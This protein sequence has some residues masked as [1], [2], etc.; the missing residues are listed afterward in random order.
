MN[1]GMVY[2]A[3]SRR[4]IPIDVATNT[5]SPL[6]LQ[7]SIADLVNHPDYQPV[8][9]RIIAKR[10]G[11]PKEEAADVR[12]MVK[13]LVQQGLVT[14]ASN[15][16]VRPVSRSKETE[17]RSQNEIERPSPS[18]ASPEGREPDE[19]QT[20]DKRV[21]DSSRGQS[22]RENAS[23]R[24]MPAPRDSGV[25][26]RTQKGFGFVR[27]TP[28]AGEEGEPR[29][30]TTRR[31]TISSSRP[32]TRSTRPAAMSWPLKSRR[33]SGRAKATPS[34]ARPAWAD[35]RNHR[36]ADAPVRRRLFR[37]A[38]L[39]LRA[40][41]RQALHAANLRRRSRREERPAGRQ[42][43]H[44]DDSL[45]VAHAR[46]RGRDR[47]SPWGAGP[48]GRRYALDHSRVRPA[49][50]VRSGRAGRCPAE[51]DRFD[52]SI[53]DRLDLTGQTIITI[54]PVDARDY[55]DAISLEKF[56][57]GHWRLGVHIADVSHFVRPR[58]AL[59][60]EAHNRATSVYLPD[61]VIPML[62][63]LI[64]NGLASLQPDRVRTRRQRSSTTRPKAFARTPSAIRRRSRAASG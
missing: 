29:R 24:S 11:L 7:S 63:E 41:R 51:A 60:R 42:S 15:H 5:M 27:P 59:D 49:R 53:G 34:S 46:R 23:A 52:E 30:K 56:D 39:G 6:E 10:L 58:T 33:S 25:F 43:G 28:P 18:A 9:P 3:F 38:R 36:A 50:R 35:R 64:S 4:M 54:D 1:G 14:Y 62:P 57:D 47:R 26:H 17:I 21:S 12:R 37:V 16:I 2:A 19:E 55:D 40:D 32:S 44:R 48:A 22:R 45:P 31:P 61:R 8:K 20:G 13:R